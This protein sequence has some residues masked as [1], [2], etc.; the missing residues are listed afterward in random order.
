VTPKVGANIGTIT[1]ILLYQQSNKEQR[2]AMGKEITER[3]NIDYALGERIVERY[4]DTNEST[5]WK[6]YRQYKDR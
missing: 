1:G 4:N 3:S 5:L 6:R 2:N